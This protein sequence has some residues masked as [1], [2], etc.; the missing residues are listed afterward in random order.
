MI[1]KLKNKWWLF[2]IISSICM[3]LDPYIGL[4]SI[5]MVV[6]L[7]FDIIMFTILKG[8]FN[9]FSKKIVSKSEHAST[10][11]KIF[12]KEIL[13]FKIGKIFTTL[14]TIFVIVVIFI[15]NIEIQKIMAPYYFLAIEQ[16]FFIQIIF[17]VLAIASIIFSCIL[18]WMYADAYK[19]SLNELEY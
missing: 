17:I 7:F 6:V 10:I 4:F 8:H 18:F 9:I 16:S 13:F 19:Q 3:Y 14:F 1:D 2:T 15:E 11:K 12:N 5:F